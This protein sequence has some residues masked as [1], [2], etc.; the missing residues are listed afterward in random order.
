MLPDPEVLEQQIS[1]RNAEFS[2]EIIDE[3]KTTEEQFIPT[4]LLPPENIP[5][6]PPIVTTIFSRLSTVD[7]EE[8]TISIVRNNVSIHYNNKVEKEIAPKLTKKSESRNHL[9]DSFIQN[10]PRI[11]KPRHEFFNPEDKA[12]Q[13]STLPDD[14][15][16]ETLARIYE[17]QGLYA[18]AIKIYEK[19]MLIIPEKSSYFAT[20][21]SE[22]ENSRK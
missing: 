3:T 10:E 6:F 20:R 9:I 19:L 1:T 22:I 17:Q 4:P 13:S 2:V 15:V 7:I 21:I 12:R 11:G 5:D 16:S 8:T 18:M 14:M